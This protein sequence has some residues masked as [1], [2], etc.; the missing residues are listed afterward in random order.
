MNYVNIICKIIIKLFFYKSVPL[1]NVFE[2]YW[3]TVNDSC[4]L[5]Y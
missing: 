1:K 5:K 4:K 3:Q 2:V